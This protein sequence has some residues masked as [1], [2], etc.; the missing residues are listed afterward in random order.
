MQC[1]I[2]LLTCETLFRHKKQYTTTTSDDVSAHRNI[3]QL[4]KSFFTVAGSSDVMDVMAHW[5]QGTAF[6]VQMLKC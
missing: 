6:V 2:D 5:K 1:C 3:T 4:R